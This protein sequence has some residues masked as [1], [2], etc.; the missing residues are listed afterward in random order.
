MPPS[1]DGDFEGDETFLLD[2]GDI[3]ID[4][5]RVH[6]GKISDDKPTSTMHVFQGPSQDSS[7][8][9]SQDSNLGQDNHQNSSQDSSQDPRQ[10]PIDPNQDPSQDQESFPDPSKSISQ[11]PIQVSDQGPNHSSNLYH[12]SKEEVI[13]KKVHWKKVLSETNDGTPFIP[14]HKVE[15]TPLTEDSEAVIADNH[16]MKTGTIVEQNNC[17]YLERAEDGEIF[18]EEVPIYD[19]VDRSVMLI[20]QSTNHWSA[21]KGASFIDLNAVSIESDT[22]KYMANPTIQE[23]AYYGAKA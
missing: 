15:A 13:L 7:Q 17:L 4:R 11:D 19:D 16:P 10:D 22:S 23:P 21:C 5:L 3:D 6:E 1:D 14:Q 12:T 8:D 18:Y 2:T 20:S 9:P